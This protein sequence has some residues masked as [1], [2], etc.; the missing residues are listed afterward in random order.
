MEEILFRSALEQA[1]LIRT[2]DISAVELARIYLRRIEQ[3]N[4]SW[5]AFIRQTKRRALLSAYRADKRRRCGERLPLFHGVPMGIKDLVPTRGIRTNFGSR[6]YRYF[7]PLFDAE[8]AKRLYAGGGVSLGKLTTS[9]FGALP[10]TEPM[11]HPPSRNPWSPNRTPGGSSGGSAAAVSGA[12]LPIAHASDGGGSIR[13]PAS[14]CHLY[15]FKPSLSLLGNLH[16]PANHLGLSV[17]GSVTHTVE[18]SAAMLDV[19]SKRIF[20]GEGSCMQALEREPASLRIHMCLQSPIGEVDSEVKAC[21]ENT[22]HI[23][24][25]LGHRVI[26]VPS[27]EGSADEF[28]PI[29]QFTFSNIPILSE[30]WVEPLTAWLRKEGKKFSK[31]DVEAI[32]QRFCARLDHLVGDADL[33]LSPTV[34]SPAPP[35]GSF[36]DGS[37]IEVFRRAARLGAFTAMFNLWKAPAASLPMGV[38]KQG[39]PLGVQIGARVGQDHLVLQV[40]RQLERA[41]PWV[42]RTH[43]MW[44]NKLGAR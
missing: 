3:Y 34:A 7:L 41:A 24:E 21:V 15:G 13:I 18:D 33:L 29:W 5:F 26:E 38:N 23:L 43:Q 31:A 8:T 25:A 17:M 40:S 6:S 30:R 9:E 39:L 28:S 11:F 42:G 44:R 27:I 36:S 20:A 2:G 16:G 37:P 32:Q 19:L 35:I 4:P 1:R 22:A 10:V 12:L 14:F